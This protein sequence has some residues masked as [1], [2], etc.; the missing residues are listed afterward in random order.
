MTNGYCALLR[1]A[2]TSTL[3]ETR[4]IVDA[5]FGVG[6]ISLTNFLAYYNAQRAS[7][8]AGAMPGLVLDIRNPARAGSV[9]EH[10]GAEHAQK[11]QLPPA[12]VSAETDANQLVRWR[13]RPHR[14]PRLPVHCRFAL[15]VD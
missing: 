1:T 12:G 11:L 7:G 10:C 4:I 13:W 15:E 6:S 5:S 3:P 9:N 2:P 14:L 8:S